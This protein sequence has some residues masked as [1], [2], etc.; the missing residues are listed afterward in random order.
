[1]WDSL[2]DIIRTLLQHRLRTFL[3][4]FGVFWGIFML[5]FLLGLGQGLKNGVESVFSSDDRTS[6][7]IN[8]MKTSVPFAG[9]PSN[10]ALQLTQ[11]DL[12]RVAALPDVAIASGE[13]A[14]GSSHRGDIYISRKAKSGSF[15]VFGV[16][17]QYFDIK[18]YQE[19]RLGRRLTAR[20]D[21][22]ARKVAVIGTAVAERI[23]SPDENPIGQDISVSGVNVTVVGVFYDSGWEGR[24]SERIY[25]PLSAFQT[26]FGLADKIGVI[27]VV[28]KPGR[29]ALGTQI[30]QL[31]KQHHRIAPED[32]VAVRVFDLAEETE[33]L[34]QTFSAVN[35]FLWLVGI[36]TL[37]AGAMGIGNVMVISVKERTQEIGLRKALG[38]R[39]WQIV[40]FI[41]VESLLLTLIAGYL[42]LVVAIGILEGLTWMTRQ[43]GM[44]LPY[45]AEPQVDLVLAIIAL[46]ILIL[47]GLIA[48]LL[49][50]WRAARVPPVAALRAG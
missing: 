38:A 23:F 45:F 48:G 11:A 37:L 29:T 49:P 4:A 32:P 18:K 8:F 27:A 3:T 17:P 1:M 43:P 15:S 47:V 44:A 12:D 7:W 19:Y 31:L 6:L 30:E 22:A 21:E 35:S 34:T 33:N 14:L 16:A 42:G 50:A 20:D 40:Q 9:L 25:M 2:T 5:V 41:L 39:P 24:M 26:V 10:R 13:L 46:G 36:G 28:P